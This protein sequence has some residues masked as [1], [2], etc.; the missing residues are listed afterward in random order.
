LANKTP[1]A[2]PP[3][4]AEFVR[5]S[6]IYQIYEYDRRRVVTGL[7]VRQQC[8]ELWR[9]GDINERMGSLGK[10]KACSALLVVDNGR[11]GKSL[12]LLF[13]VRNVA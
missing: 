5:I 10:N 2:C 13:S 7:L 6:L 11:F 8:M 1:V 9:T 12:T 3:Q 4:I